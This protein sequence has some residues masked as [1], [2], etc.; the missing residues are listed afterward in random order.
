LLAFKAAAIPINIKTNRISDNIHKSRF[1]FQSERACLRLARQD[2]R[3][4]WQSS[5]LG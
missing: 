3:P 4:R 1:A 5:F 2:A